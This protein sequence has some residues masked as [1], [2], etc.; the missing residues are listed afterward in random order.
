MAQDSVNVLNAA[1]GDGWAAYQADCVPFTAQMPD[2]SVDLTVYSPPFSNLYIYSDSPRD[3]G[4]CADDAE[5]I[6]SYMHVISELHRVTRPGRL[7]AVH[8]KDLVNY[9]NRDGMAGLRDFP[10]DLIRAHQRVGFSFHSRVTIWKCPVTEMQRT[11]AHGLLYKQLRRDSSFSRVGLAEYLLLFRRWAETD[12]DPDVRPIAHTYEQFPL[13]TWQE[14]ASPIWDSS[15]TD[16]DHK[17]LEQLIE[18]SSPVWKDIEQT[19]VLN[20]KLARE[21]RDEKHICPLQLDVIER[22]VGLWSNPG[23]T[24]YSPYGGIGSEGYQSLLM[25]RRFVACELKER[26]WEHMVRNLKEAEIEAKG[27]QQELFG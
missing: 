14:W 17:Q 22:A 23:E 7:V 19:N 11:K 4:N 20:I 12:D 15:A 16:F 3:M 5:F 26:Y 25:G 24:V 13:D 18:W 9:K 2:R 10:G 27:R 21:D 8:C 1:E 6:D